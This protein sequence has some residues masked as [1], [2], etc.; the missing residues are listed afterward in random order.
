MNQPGNTPVA[1]RVIWS[2][3]RSI[4]RMS[5]A[6]ADGTSAAPNST[7]VH[8]RNTAITY[9]SIVLVLFP[10]LSLPRDRSA[11]DR[12]HNRHPGEMIFQAHQHGSFPSLG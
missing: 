5:R 4:Y 11:W 1:G 9:Y 6:R 3:F 8:P 2:K 12:D 7:L 10:D